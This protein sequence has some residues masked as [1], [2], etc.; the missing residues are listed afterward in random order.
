MDSYKIDTDVLRLIQANEMARD[1][2]WIKTNLIRQGKA[3]IEHAT[4]LALWPTL[5][6]HAWVE[7]IVRLN[8]YEIQPYKINDTIMPDR[9]TVFKYLVLGA[10]ININATELS[11]QDRLKYYIKH[12]IKKLTTK[13]YRPYPQPESKRVT[14]ALDRVWKFLEDLAIAISNEDDDW[15][16]EDLCDALIGG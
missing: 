3:I 7:T 13:Q 11:A 12:C 16:I 6:T 10:L 1:L 9:D 8:R 5:C 14:Q 2:D 4:K 15:Y